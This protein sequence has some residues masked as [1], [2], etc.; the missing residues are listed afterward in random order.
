LPLLLV[1]EVAAAHRRADRDRGDGDEGLVRVLEDRRI[2]LDLAEA[3]QQPPALDL[4]HL[5]DAIEAL[6]IGMLR[7]S[8]H[9]V[10]D[11]RP[12]DFGELGD[13]ASVQAQLLA[14][15]PEPVGQ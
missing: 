14:A 12:I 9:D 6:E 15:G 5:G 1:D 8:A 11:E 13:L 7:A 3:V 2:A 4:E 10:V